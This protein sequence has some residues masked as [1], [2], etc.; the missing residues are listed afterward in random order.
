MR[1]FIINNMSEL[2]D[3]I[4]TLCMSDNGVKPWW[5]GQA[6]ID[7]DLEASVYRSDC[8]AKERYMNGNF[9]L[10]AG[11]RCSNCPSESNW[12]GWLFLMQH[13]RLPTRLLDWSESALI[14]LYFALE[15][16]EYYGT[17]SVVWA[18]KA[19]DLNNHEIEEDTIFLPGKD[20]VKDIFRDA[21]LNS[22]G[23]RSNKIAAVR[24]PQTDIR[25]LIQQ[26]A[27]TIHG[28][29]SCLNK[30]KG[31]EH[32]L[33]RLIIKK[34]QKKYFRNA[35]DHFGICRSYVFPDLENLAQDMS[36]GSF[37]VDNKHVF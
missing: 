4:D 23:S 2:M 25:H 12:S 14:A 20:K 21:F 31:S 22:G 17:D 16:T 1:D 26:P 11:T 7:W 30:I 10:Y 9:M 35:L 34:E 28:R 8:S 6:D 19:G 13:Y 3:A 27:F 33:A 37:F 18:L 36:N 24:A 15:P 29:E 32:F 5:R